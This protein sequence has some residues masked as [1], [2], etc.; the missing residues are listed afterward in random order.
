MYPVVFGDNC[1][2]R[3]T[4]VDGSLRNELIEVLMARNE[5]ADMCLV[6]LRFVTDRSPILADA[7]S[8]KEEERVCLPRRTTFACPRP[9]F[10]K[11][12]PFIVTFWPSFTVV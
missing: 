1:L 4:L 3:T 11:T 6:S 10:A 12:V 8:H 2:P 7:S 9:F 5:S